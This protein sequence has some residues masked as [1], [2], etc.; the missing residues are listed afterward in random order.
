MLYF[1][2][3]VGNNAQWLL[4]YRASTHGWESSTFHER[5]DGKPN[6]VTIVKVGDFVFGGY[7]DIPW[8]N[9]CL[10]GLHTTNLSLQTRVGKL[11]LVCVNGTKTVGKHVG[12]LLATNRTCL[13]SRQLFRQLF[14]VGKLEF[15]V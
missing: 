8:G 11:K 2:P 12:K 3:N 13:Y 15:D 5:C 7:T 9:F 10:R 4:C 14:R 6:T 1:E